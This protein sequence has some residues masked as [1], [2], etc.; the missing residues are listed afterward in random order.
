MKFGIMGNMEKPQLVSVTTGLLRSL[1]KKKVEY[2]VADELADRVNRE[3]RDTLV[4]DEHRRSLKVLPEYSDLLIAFGGDGTMLAAARLVG[5]RGTPI[6]GVNLGKLGF[7]AEISVE[8]LHTS[9][10]EILQNHYIIEDRMVLEAMVAGSSTRFC[11]LN[12]IVIDKSGLARVINLKTFVD[13]EYLVTYTADGIIIATPTGSTAYSLASGGPIVVPASR[14][15]TLTPISPHT[16]TAR[17]VILP[18][19]STITV[20]VDGKAKAVHVTA[21][22]QF[23][24]VLSPPVTFRIHRGDY[25][26]RLVK[27]MDR[28]YYDVLR[29]KLMWGRDVRLSGSQDR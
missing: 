4:D 19:T 3:A 26:V 8:D 6:L 18:D 11:G 23:E 1:R 22:G 16:L 15:I 9:I 13:E 29:T 28:S 25:T 21:D 12:D 5:V 24:E 14:V 7:L 20:E 10:D 27:R 2:F 17:P